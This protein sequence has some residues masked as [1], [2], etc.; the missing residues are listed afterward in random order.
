M[1]WQPRER[2]KC[3]RERDEENEQERDTVPSKVLEWQG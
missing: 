3:D 2:R 1:T